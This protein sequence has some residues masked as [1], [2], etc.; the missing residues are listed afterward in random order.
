MFILKILNTLF[1]WVVQGIAIAS[2]WTK[3]PTDKI[4]HFLAGGII[5]FI[6]CLIGNYSA[7]STIGFLIAALLPTTIIGAAKELAYDKAMG[8]GNPE[9]MDFIATLLGGIVV[10]GI[11]LLIL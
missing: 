8:K 6:G 10:T 7:E 9:W 11:M 2:A 4:M 5:S 1:Y 3:I